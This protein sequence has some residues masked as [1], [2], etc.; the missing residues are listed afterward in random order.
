MAA[1]AENPRKTG[2]TNDHTIRAGFFIV[3]P[4]S[5]LY[6][7]FIPPTGSSSVGKAS[8][9]GSRERNGPV[10]MGLA[11][12]R[13]RLPAFGCGRQGPWK[14]LSRGSNAGPNPHEREA[15]IEIRQVFEAEDFGSELTSAFK[16]REERLCTQTGALK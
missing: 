4:C 5:T 3:R 12:P 6:I 14:R 15:D 2:T 9:S 13:N 11:R 7:R 1:A 8:E 16:K 10:I